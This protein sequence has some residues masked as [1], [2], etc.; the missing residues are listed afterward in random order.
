V[1]GHP[2]WITEIH[3]YQTAEIVHQYLLYGNVY[4]LVL[5]EGTL[6]D[7]PRYLS[8]RQY[9]SRFLKEIEGYRL[10]LFYSQSGGFTARDDET[11]QL[12]NDLETA[13]PSASFASGTARTTPTEP[14]P[15]VFLEEVAD[16]F[17]PRIRTPMPVRQA[18][19]L[20]DQLLRQRQ[21]K[22]AII[23]EHIEKLAP[24][25]NPDRDED[26]NI[27]TLRRWALD[28]DIQAETNNL[29]VGLTHNQEEVDDDIYGADSR[30]RLIRVPLPSEGEREAFLEVLAGQYEGQFP[31][32]VD[33][34]GGLRLLA[35]LT[36]GFMLAHLD[37]L[38]RRAWLQGKRITKEL[39]KAMKREIIR[40]ESANLLEEKEPSFGFEAIGGLEHIKNY[41]LQVKEFLIKREN[42]LVPKGILLAGPPGT[43]KTLI[44]EALARETG[45][46]VV[47]MGNIRDKWVGASERNLS[48]ILQI[49]VD[50][51]P[52]IVFVDEIDQ[53]LGS[54]GVGGSGD[55][56]TSERMF[57]KI[58]EFMGSNEH[59]GSI[60]WVA[61]T[62]RADVLDEAMI[63]R[64]DRVFPVLI[65]GTPQER[66]A[67][68]LALAR[69]IEGLSFEES[70]DTALKHLSKESRGTTSSASPQAHAPIQQFGHD[71]GG[72]TGSD[73]EIIVRRAKE[74]ARAEPVSGE[75][76]NQ[77]RRVFKSNHHQD[78]YDLQTMLAVTACNFIDTIPNP[79]AFPEHLRPVIERVLREKN[80]SPLEQEI[81]ELKNRL[82]I[83]KMV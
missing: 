23:L 74:Y 10:V 12:L 30:C 58:L 53:A 14:S 32:T 38:Y 72:L 78:M 54:R 47:R 71:T 22:V 36:K 68:T 42:A 20:I 56:G 1:A 16:R 2:G 51:A 18:F 25:D 15:S 67:I 37:E 19:S 33:L 65:P 11:A 39:V 3:D 17:A 55:S 45:R 66:L 13:R 44:A 29:L 80:N 63:R 73:L 4:D 59:R 8:F 35:Q 7:G 69:Q 79:S 34:E 41:L 28:I 5:T 61:A 31:I 48:R 75:H 57:A 21:H 62:N 81:T 60:I 82:G 43:G 26:L 49:I 24:R 9:L 64:F 50:N 76:L 6:T 27:E 77:A 40:T 52:V 83:K 46:N 70:T